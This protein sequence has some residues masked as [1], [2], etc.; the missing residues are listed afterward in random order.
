[1]MMMS[2]PAS[3]LER[4]EV[5]TVEGLDMPVSELHKASG[6]MPEVYQVDELKQIEDALGKGLPADEKAAANIAM[7]RMQGQAFIQ[8]ADATK[9]GMDAVILA[10]RLNLQ[11]VPAVVFDRHYIVYGEQPMTAY[12]IYQQHREAA[13]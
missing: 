7:K 1:M 4:I 10:D 2:L 13:N 12:A 6:I 5:F 11:A 8:Q 3:A 9:R